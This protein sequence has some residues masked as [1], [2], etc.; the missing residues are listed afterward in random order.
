[1]CEICL[2]SVMQTRIYTIL[3]GKELFMLWYY[4]YI[5]KYIHINIYTVNLN[6]LF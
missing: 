3:P 1:M 5:Y 2:V 4:I 6:G